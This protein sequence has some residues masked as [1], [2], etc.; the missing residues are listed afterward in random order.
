MTKYPFPLV[1]SATLPSTNQALYVRYFTATLIDL[2]VLN[3]FDEYW[4]HV[5]IGSFTISLAAAII[6][7]LLLKLTL[8]LEHKVADFFNARPGVMFK[9]M[10]Y[11]GAWLILFG[12]KFVMLEAISIA[13]GDKVNFGGPMHGVV[14]FIAVVIVMVIAE[15]LVMRLYRRLG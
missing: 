9:F 5:V 4:Q 8:W 7:Q 2:V 10:R 13:F 1:A 3:L 15:E 12:S 11:F 14:A 6:L